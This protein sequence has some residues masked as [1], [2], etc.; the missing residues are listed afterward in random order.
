MLRVKLLRK[1]RL[2]CNATKYGSLLLFAGNGKLLNG[3]QEENDIKCSVFVNKTE[4]LSRKLLNEK[5]DQFTI[6]ETNGEFYLYNL[7]TYQMYLM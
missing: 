3:T 1:K 6:M 7:E 4:L 5:I 2:F